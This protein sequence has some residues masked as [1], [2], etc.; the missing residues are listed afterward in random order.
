MATK[1]S[2]ALLLVMT[3]MLLPAVSQTYASEVAMPT[4]DYSAVTPQKSGNVPDGTLLGRGRITYSA[5]HVGFIL[6]SDSERT[7]RPGGYI[8]SGINNPGNKLYIRMEAEGAV[9]DEQQRGIII[10][11]NQSS[12]PF[13]IKMDGNQNIVSDKWSFSINTIAILP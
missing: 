13:S 6:G 8:L 5:P 1:I 12:V 3:A 2:P 4:I 11:T 9:E 7:N 10:S